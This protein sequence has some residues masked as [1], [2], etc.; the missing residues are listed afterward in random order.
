[1]G[2]LVAYALGSMARSPGIFGALLIAGLIA[3]VAGMVLGFPALGATHLSDDDRRTGFTGF[4][5]GTVGVVLHVGI[6][7]VFVATLPLS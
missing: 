7:V 5:S 6:V 1:M 2:P 4:F 3:G